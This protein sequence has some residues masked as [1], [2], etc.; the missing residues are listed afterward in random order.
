M[1]LWPGI[2][3]RQC[4]INIDFIY[5]VFNFLF[6]AWIISVS[7]R[8]RKGCRHKALY[9][10][11]RLGKFLDSW[12]NPFRCRRKFFTLA[13]YIR[14]CFPER[15]TR[16]AVLNQN[17]GNDCVTHHGWHSR[18]QCHG[19]SH[20]SHRKMKGEMNLQLVRCEISSVFITYLSSASWT[21]APCSESPC[22]HIICECADMLLASHHDN[23]LLK[24][25]KPQLARYWYWLDLP[26]PRERLCF[27]R[28]AFYNTFN[29]F[30]NLTASRLFERS[31]NHE[32]S[33]T[34]RKNT[35]IKLSEDSDDQLSILLA[36]GVFLIEHGTVDTISSS[37]TFLPFWKRN[38][39]DGT[40]ILENE[41]ELGSN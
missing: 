5:S 35:I 16:R 4:L 33:N 8:N 30:V 27:T 10:A 22:L 2:D 38:C 24:Y 31:C 15:N 25:L 13:I 12:F 6:E 14:F 1:L 23:C 20:R 36:T 17:L 37:H 19:T 7:G 28:P 18:A 40:V 29:S 21:T 41:R 11:T 32:V 34:K 26:W 39:I 3:C 9:D